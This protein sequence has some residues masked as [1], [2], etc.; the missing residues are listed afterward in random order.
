[1]NRHQRRKEN[2]KQSKAALMQTELLQAIKAHTN[3]DLSLAEGMYQKLYAKDNTNYDLVR[4]LGILYQDLKD[5]EKAYNYFL[6][7]KFAINIKGCF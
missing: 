1:M 3:G 7:A 2:K 5:N 4:H 6:K